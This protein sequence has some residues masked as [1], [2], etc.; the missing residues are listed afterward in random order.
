[1]WAMVKRVDAETLG[2][3]RWPWPERP[4]VVVEDADRVRG[5]ETATALRRAGYAV[6]V[7]R[8][9]FESPEGRALC[10]LERLEECLLVD[11]ADVVV[12][13]LATRTKGQGVLE[14]LLRRRGGRGLVVELES[15]EADRRRGDLQDC[16]VIPAAASPE[17]IVDAVGKVL[18]RDAALRR[19]RYS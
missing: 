15:E 11:D 7:C 19:A 5:L 10:P 14:G 18:E 2:Q 8:G 17:T 13:R 3:Q 9:P 6:A 12:W 16:D 4:R 1:M